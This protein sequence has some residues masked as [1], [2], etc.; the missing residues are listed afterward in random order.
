MGELAAVLYGVGG[1]IWGAVTAQSVEYLQIRRPRSRLLRMLPVATGLVTLHCLLGVAGALAPAERPRLVV[2]LALLR[3]VAALMGVAVFRHV[4]C[5]LP[6]K[7]EPPGRTW[8]VVHYGLAAGVVALAIAAQTVRGSW[9]SLSDMM[10]WLTVLTLSGLCLAQTARMASG[11]GFGPGGLAEM[12]RPDV[13]V[14]G[15]GLVAGLTTI[16]VFG[17]HGIG[18][19]VA[20]VTITL[21]AAV[22]VVMRMLGNVVRRVLI[23]TA[24]LATTALI[25][26]THGLAVARAGAVLR[27]L[28][29]LTTVLVLALALV[30]GYRRLS[31]V[32]DRA[33]FR[34]RQRAIAQL[35]AFLHTLSP[36]LGALEC[37]R[38][39]L[40][41][42]GR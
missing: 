29:D 23:T 12:R 10:V 13:I 34:R 11:K 32:V 36:E 6:A 14:I 18:R 2:W 3:D 40:L 16:V 7:E 4:L 22:P 30:P 17:G 31:T 1:L 5:Y 27:P 26:T 9:V 21:A 41:E 37:C 19:V 8:L 25:L 20:D 42:I 33:V 35:Q 38:R 39:V 28:L 15:T 24:T